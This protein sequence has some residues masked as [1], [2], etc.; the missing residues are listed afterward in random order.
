MLSALQSY[1]WPGNVRELRNHIERSVVMAEGF[2]IMADDMFPDWRVDE[3]SDVAVNDQPE[4][5]S[6]QDT[7]RAAIQQKVLAALETTGGNQTEAAHL[8]GV[9]RTTIWK[10]KG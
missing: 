6:L 2:T 9:S 10:Y 5:V 4:Q 1:D 7:A 8:L 3:P